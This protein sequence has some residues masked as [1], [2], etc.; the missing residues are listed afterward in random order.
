M[1]ARRN[2]SICW[3]VQMTKY[4]EIQIASK[5]VPIVEAC[6]FLSK[7]RKKSTRQEMMF[8]LNVGSTPTFIQISK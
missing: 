4:L 8:F 5:S 3:N 1:G 7:F 2:S 6:D